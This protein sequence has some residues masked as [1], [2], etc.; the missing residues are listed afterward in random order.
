M[1]RRGK[2]EGTIFYSKPHQR[3]IGQFNNGYKENGKINRKTVYGKTRREVK[4][5][6]LE[7]QDLVA[8]EKY[9]DKSTITFKDIANDIA[10]TKFA[11]NT[12]GE[13][14]YGRLKATIKNLGSFGNK[15]IQKITVREVQ[16]YLNKYVNYTS[17]TIDR[18]YSLFNQVFKY[19]IQRKIL[20]TNPMDLVIKPK[21][22]LVPKKREFAFTVEEEKL[23]LDNLENEKYQI[24]FLI[25]FHTG[26]RIGEILAL[27]PEDINFEKKLITINKTLTKDINGKTKLGKKTKTINGMRVIPYIDILEPYLK[28][29]VN[30]YT[31]NPNHLLFHNDKN[32]IATS[33]VNSQFKRICKNLGISVKPKIITRPGKIINSKTSDVHVHMIRHTYATRCIES[34]MPPVVLQ[35]LL[36]HHDV[37]ITLNTYTSVFNSFQADSL[38]SYI[39]YMNN[40]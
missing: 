9:C 16:N 24:V 27:T 14:G 29:A 5:K 34:G 18:Q 21:T 19:A 40:L 33:T 28:I 22:K 30:N 3:W 13:S 8:K 39:D 32:V 7:M 26:M 2:G 25:A 37:S 1:V 31:K 10:E 15:E 4:D 35:R 6:L 20:N 36:G 12:L 23:I 38:K 11:S 17:C